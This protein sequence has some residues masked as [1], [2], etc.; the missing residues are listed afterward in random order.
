MIRA[1]L[2]KDKGKKIQVQ[3]LVSHCCAW[4]AGMLAVSSLATAG[5]SMHV[6]RAL[7]SRR[8]VLAVT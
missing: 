2:R 7:I 3:Y 8:C 6:F 5:E 4:P 1:V